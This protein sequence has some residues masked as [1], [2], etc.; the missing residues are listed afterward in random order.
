MIEVDRV[1]RNGINKVLLVEDSHFYAQIVEGLLPKD[2]YA[3]ISVPSG[4]E[5]IEIISQ[6]RDIAIVLMDVVLSGKLDGIKTAEEILRFKDLPI[7]FLTS[8]SD[9]ETLEKL[10][11]SGAYG[12]IPKGTEGIALL[13]NV[14]MVLKLHETRLR[15]E[16]KE[17]TLRAILN[18][19]KDGI[20]L[21][22]D[23]CRVLFANP[24]AEKIFGHT[25]SE[26][27]GKNLFFLLEPEW[28]LD[29]ISGDEVKEEELQYSKF[30]EGTELEV[31]FKC[32]K[33]G[34]ETFVDMSFSPLEIEGKSYFVV[35]G[36]DAT[37]HKE[38]ED[39][40]LYLSI[41]D[42]LTGAYNRRY[43]EQRL[44]EELERA[45]RFGTVFSVV[46]FDLDH[47]KRV[48]DEF[49][50]NIGDD[51]LK[52]VTGVVKGRL[53][54]IDTLG[55]WGGEEFLIILP[56]TVLENAIFLAEELRNRIEQE[57]IPEVGR[58]TASFGVAAFIDGE[59]YKGLVK[60]ADD[61]LYKAK[62]EGRNCVRFINTSV[63]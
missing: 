12:Y 14:N 22:D 9:P 2:S 16:E 8:S 24:A 50:H 23:I 60:R 18:T 61:A 36:K 39:R 33:N 31:K 34:K 49:G 13:S 17:A 54:Q 27:S 3:V 46:M 5:A 44:K 7:L 42:P 32:E 6:D 38:L 1:A 35:V 37:K 26:M 29:L 19:A 52:R 11:G 62:A 59:S 30:L 4:E 53:R 21:L 48:N 45:K 43:T 15:L 55:R 63:V 20:L 28:I 10:K 41:T 25:Y 47:F 51:V 56:G 58:C 57:H 40:L